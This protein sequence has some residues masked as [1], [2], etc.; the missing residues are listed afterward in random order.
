MSPIPVEDRMPQTHNSPF[1]ARTTIDELLDDIWRIVLEYLPPLDILRLRRT[2]KIFASLSRDRSIWFTVLRSVCREQHLFMPTSALQGMT[3]AQLE[4]S[5]LQP[6]R[7][8]NRLKA[9]DIS[10][11]SFTS[12]QLSHS[13]C[14]LQVDVP[15]HDGLREKTS[16]IITTPG[17][18]YLLRIF[19]LVDVETDRPARLSLVTTHTLQLWDIGRPNAAAP[20]LVASFD[21]DGMHENDGAIDCILLLPSSRELSKLRVIIPLRMHDIP[22][23]GSRRTCL[24]QVYEIDMDAEAPSFSLV[25]SH[26]NVPFMGGP[27]CLYATSDRLTCVTDSSHD[28]QRQDVTLLD[29]ESDMMDLQHFTVQFPETRFRYDEVSRFSQRKL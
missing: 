17:G 6:Y 28:P 5:S 1:R 2:A 27:Q 14:S 19:Y 3:T 10:S 7:T 29:L 24:L 25:R 22:S 8:F 21:V 18:I 26:P 11:A 12:P 4:R 16:R 13:N 15:L 9:G 23:L 20:H